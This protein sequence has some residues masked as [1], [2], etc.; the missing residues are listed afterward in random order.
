[1][2]P[3]SCQRI[4]ALCN[5]FLTTGD[6]REI[7]NMVSAIEELEKRLTKITPATQR[8][9][10]I[11]ECPLLKSI[12]TVIKLLENLLL[13]AMEGDD[14]RDMAERGI[15]LYQSAPDIVFIV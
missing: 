10:D 13:S 7:Y 14:V 2:V 3:S 1:M 12:C 9:S 6:Y 11:P 5:T 4:Q 8:W 15:L